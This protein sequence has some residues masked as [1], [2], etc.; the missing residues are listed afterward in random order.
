MNSILLIGATGGLGQ[1]VVS[2]LIA[3]KEQFKRVALVVDATRPASDEK[4]EYLASVRKSGIEVVTTHGYCNPAVYRGFDCL[5]TFLGHHAFH[6]QTE[7]FEAAFNGGIRHFYP[8]EYGTDLT[9]GS[10]WTQR[11]YRDKIIVRNALQKMGEQNSDLGWTYFINGL[12]AEIAILGVFGV[13]HRNRTGRIYGSP[14]ASLSM[15][16][17]RDAAKYI[18]ATLK[19]PLDQPSKGHRRTYRITGAT[20]T[21]DMYFRTLEEVTGVK[22]DVKYLDPELGREKAADAQRQ[23]NFEGEMFGSLQLIG[24]L[25]GSVLPTPL[26][27]DRFPEIKTTPIA[28]AWRDAFDSPRW[29]RRL[30][31]E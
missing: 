14:K 27:N 8:S 21:W 11:Y 2:E 26:D 17:E 24:N 28:E 25:G 1:V 18:V 9:A 4:T 23:G 31:L 13:D 6:I 10:N 30:R 29:R 20:M 16:A 3:Q 15:L 22:Y 12:F 7:I 19:D 5:M